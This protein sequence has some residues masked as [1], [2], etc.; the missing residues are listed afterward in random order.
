MIY[1]LLP[2]AEEDIEQI[3]DYL[4]ERSPPAAARLV[5]AF[6]EKWLRLTHFPHLGIEREDIMPGIQHVVVALYRVTEE[7]I[8]IVRVFHGHR[9]I[10][11][12][13]L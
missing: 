4:A 12:G 10:T 9:H 1:Y 8:E 2:R 13:H 7:G 6:H 5:E 3:G 11:A